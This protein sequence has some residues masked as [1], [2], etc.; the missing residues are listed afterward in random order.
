MAN[1]TTLDLGVI[2]PIPKGEYNSVTDY[3]RLNFVTFNGSSWIRTE[4][5][6]YVVG[7]IPQTGSLYW[8]LMAKKGDAG[9]D[10]AVV[11]PPLITGSNDAVIG[12][13]TNY[14]L[15]STSMLVGNNIA[16]FDYRLGSGDTNTVTATNNGADIQVAVP[17]NTPVGTKIPI[18][19]TAYDN[20]GYSNYNEKQLTSITAKIDSPTI[21]NINEGST[22]VLP[23]VTIQVGSFIVSPSGFDTPNKFTYWFKKQSDNTV[24]ETKTITISASGGVFKPTIELPINTALYLECK[25]VGSKIESSIKR[26]NFTT[27]NAYIKP[28]LISGVSDG[29]IGVALKPTFSIGSFDVVPNGYDSPK[30]LLYTI[31]K[32]SDNTV[33]ETNS[34]IISSVGGSFKPVNNLPLNTPLKITAK[35]IGNKLISAETIVNFTTLSAQINAPIFTAPVAGAGVYKD[36]IMAVDRKSVV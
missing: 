23:N 22:D 7:S 32:T 29:Q 18:F 2:T 21:I 13:N 8:Q 6:P 36:L 17:Q 34:V 20:K 26:V 9:A 11:T 35:W 27:I 1:I 31:S 33:V 25:W 3:E 10:V 15:S 16:S 24:I 30:N 5:E 28:P 4:K 14:S 19:V 12:F